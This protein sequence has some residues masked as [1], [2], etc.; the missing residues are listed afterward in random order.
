ME[1]Y[2]VPFREPLA[3]G[4]KRQVRAIVDEMYA[5]PK[6]N[7]TWYTLR[8]HALPMPPPSIQAVDDT[9]DREILRRAFGEVCKHMSEG[10]GLGEHKK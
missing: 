8:L 7:Y 3:D 5:D 9:P 1:T 2:M 6:P 10:Y 4:Y